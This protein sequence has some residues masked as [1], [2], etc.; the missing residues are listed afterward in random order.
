MRLSMCL[1]TSAASCFLRAPSVPLTLTLTLAPW[2]QL[3]GGDFE[4]RVRVADSEDLRHLTT[5]L[6]REEV[7][8]PSPLAPPPPHS[9]PPPPLSS[10]PRP[11]AVLSGAVACCIELRDAVPPCAGS[12]KGRAHRDRCIGR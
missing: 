6:Q 2:P 8:L 11:A 12:R 4:A 1:T 9:P 5:M 3:A 10:A 7:R